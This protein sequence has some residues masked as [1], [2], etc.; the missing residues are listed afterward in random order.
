MKSYND[1]HH[2]IA[3]RLAGGHFVFAYILYHFRCEQNDV[4][5]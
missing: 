3:L 5:R 2:V 1:C 4:S